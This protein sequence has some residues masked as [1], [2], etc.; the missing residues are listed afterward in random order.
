MKHLIPLI[1]VQV[2][3]DITTTVS[4]QIPEHEIPI[5]QAA[6]G[7]DNVYPGAP[8]GTNTAIDADEEY[9]RL[10]RKLGTD[11]V[12]E[13]Y[14]IS[15]KGDIRRAVVAASLGEAEDDGPAIVLEGPDSKPEQ[16][17]HAPAAP[18]G[19]PSAQWSKAQLSDYA[20]DHGITVDP[21]ATKAV[22]LAAIKAA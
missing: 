2:H 13:A 1:A 6:H 15:A 8:L 5:M 20:S 9:D 4:V 22:I 16:V 18:D 11:A 21:A 3:R 17:T 14:G 19:E 10:C 12:R 7:E